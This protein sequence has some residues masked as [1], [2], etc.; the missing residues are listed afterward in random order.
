MNQIE[1]KYLGD[2]ANG[3]VNADDADFLV[4]VNQLVNGQNIRF[5]STDKG[6]VGNGEY[7]G[8][9]RLLS[10]PQPSVSTIIIGSCADEE[11]GLFVKFKYDIYSTDHSI[12]CYIA[13]LDQEFLV[14]LAGSIIG[15]LNFSKHSPIHSAEIIDGRLYW[16][17]STNN[18]QRYIDLYRAIKASNPSFVT[19]KV[20]Y[21]FP[22]DFSEITLIKPPPTLSP[23]I[24][25]SYDGSFSNNFIA[26]QSF[27]A[28][29]EY[30][31]YS[32]ETSVI[33]PY[34]IAS[35]L[36]QA[37]A[38]DNFIA[39]TMDS[40]QYILS[41]VRMVRLV[42]R[43]GNDNIAKVVRTWDKEIAADALAI[44][45]HNL[46]IQQ[47]TYNFY[48]DISGEA[49]PKEN[50]L[51][52]YDS[53]PIYSETLSA[54]RN[55]IFLG[56]NTD[57]YDAPLST[58][59][60]ATLIDSAV[61]GSV[62]V[63]VPIRAFRCFI[64]VPGPS[65]DYAYGAWFVYLDATT[66][67]TPGYY[68]LNGTAMTLVGGAFWTVQP[69]LAVPP[70]STSLAG[71]TF[72]GATVAD[73]FA[74]ILASAPPGSV[75]DQQAVFSS[76]YTLTV[77][78]L[79]SFI[80]SVFKTKSSYRYGI[81]FYDF[82]MRKCG[83]VT[84]DGCIFEIPGRNY[85][86]TVG[87][88][89]VRWNLSNANALAEIPEWA[90][91]YSVVRTLNLKTRFFISNFDKT[92]RYV[93]K[94]AAGLNVYTTTSYSTNVT[95]IG[96]ST[97]ALVKSGLG[98]V[99]N[100]GDVCVLID[101]SSN[102]YE[103][104]VIGQDG[105]RIILK[106]QDVGPLTNKKFIYEIYTPYKTSEQEPYYEI[107]EIYRVT[108]PGKS[109][110]VYSC[111]SDVFRAD[112]FAIS[113]N[114]D[115]DTYYGEA[116]CPNDLFYKRW[117]NDGGKPNFVTKLGQAQN[118]N[119]IR[120]SN[121]FIPNT[122]INGLSTFDA[123]DFETIPQDC[124]PIQKLIL[125]SKVQGEGTVMLAICTNETNSVYLGETQIYD[126]NGNS[127]FFASSGKVISS[128][129][130]LKGSFGTIDPTSV[131]SFRGN[132]YW[133]DRPNAKI[134][135]YSSNGLF[136]ISNYKMSR[137]WK[138]FCDL[139]SS[140]TPAQIEALG[141]RPYVFS[142]IDPY[143][144]ELLFSIPKLSNTPPKGYLPDYPSTIYPFDIWDA[145]G[146][147]MVF[148]LKTEPN[149]W[150]PSYSFN[151][152]YFITLNNKLYSFYNGQTYE[153][154][155]TTNYNE[156]YGVQ[157]EAK[158]MFL[159]NQENNRPKVYN[160]ISIESNDGT[161]IPTL[162]YFRSESPY[163]QA[164]DLKDFDYKD[165]EGNLYATIYRNKLVPSATGMSLDGLLTAEKMRTNV[166]K[167]M[168]VF[169]VG[170]EPLELRFVNVY[171]DISRGHTT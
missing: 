75:L 96:L 8:G 36:N 19:D 165:K 106:A 55:R 144:G 153:H 160:A 97:T 60:S 155:Q 65:N 125:T 2:A 21:T 161:V 15:G 67:A 25:K 105:N 84:N 87:I 66:G 70:T 63:S 35:R 32:N 86:F 146:K 28:A 3:G 149:H 17:D 48:N 139:F 100:E 112:A 30:I 117:D 73:A 7:I 158:I 34:S 147:T 148:D 27:Q 93:T 4:G 53:V 102:Q 121:T 69:I 162:T 38:S 1:K 168:L 170:S 81:V 14:V 45:N 43:Y 31:Y 12:W 164:S 49:I 107:G 24:A 127:P 124:G 5:G 98:Y 122:A 37:D 104:P 137:F 143:H 26:N 123:L 88:T 56:D 133:L 103:I 163:V 50:V 54:A 78:G 108:D 150:C 46:L 41:T 166:L 92:T 136:P 142:A 68:Y 51:K 120:W 119:V 72:Y 114:F 152:E 47:L 11:N 156:F 109:S 9:T 20:P 118:T 42:I 145:Q 169:T 61:A 126:A 154:N 52:P 134:V 57:G 99:F 79:S 64:G 110:R 157:Y 159:C 71:L 89:A 129:N 135:Q 74:V 141:G 40:S 116:M 13:E 91:Y 39:V 171:Y 128:I 130:T 44:S 140:M 10:V 77:T 23:N 167:T 94:D 82:A 80:Y 101:D 18:Q 85:G 59:L 90:Y 95:G 151:P 33:G 115:V 6:Q 22:L 29:F 111:L 138:L 62:T 58:S 16:V 132:V 113:R 76:S 83:V 131:C